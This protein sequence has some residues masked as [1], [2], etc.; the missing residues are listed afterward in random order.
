MKRAASF[1]QKRSWT[2]IFC[3]CIMFAS[4]IK[5]QMMMNERELRSTAVAA[6]WGAIRRVKNGWKCSIK[7]KF[8]NFETS[9][10]LKKYPVL[11]YLKKTSGSILNFWLL[12]EIKILIEKTTDLHW[13]IFIVAWKYRP[14]IGK[15]AFL[16]AYKP[17]IYVWK[18]I[19]KVYRAILYCS[20][21]S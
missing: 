10:K 21:V 3:G 6:V 9:S 11:C 12:F 4:R 17:I 16:V 14:E 13:K 19:L 20:N 5:V 1:G 7:N 2:V 15:C 8:P 18:I